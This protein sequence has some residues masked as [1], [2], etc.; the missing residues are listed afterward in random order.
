MFI[1]EMNFGEGQGLDIRLFDANVYGVTTFKVEKLRVNMKDLKFDALISIPK[2]MT[3]SKYQMAFKFFGNNLKTNGDYF[4]VHN[5]VKLI[6]QIKLKKII[7]NGIE[8]IRVEPIPV[9]FDNGSIS[10]LK[11]SNLFGGNKAIEEIIHAILINNPEFSAG[12][13]IPVIEASLSS[14]FT[15]L[16]NKILDTTT[17]DEMF[18]ISL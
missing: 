17:F 4:I 13:S 14:I 7:K 6:L 15:D 16:A 11:I 9:Q 3:Y 1:K 5:N 8:V 18:P 10:Q 12:N 2:L